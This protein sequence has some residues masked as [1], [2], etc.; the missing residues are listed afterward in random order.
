MMD[1][2]EFA[3]TPRDVWY[4]NGITFFTVAEIFKNLLWKT[5]LAGWG[6][7]VEFRY[8]ALNFFSQWVR[9]CH[10]VNYVDKQHHYCQQGERQDIMGNRFSWFSFWIG[11]LHGFPP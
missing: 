9:E 8:I 4:C 6:R 10:L 3:R 11:G 7:L 5:G 1:I 2:A